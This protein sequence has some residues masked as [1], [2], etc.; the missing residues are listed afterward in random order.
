MMITDAEH[1]FMF[2]LA[3]LLCSLEKCLFDFFAHLVGTLF[4]ILLLSFMSS[5]C[6]WILTPYHN[7]P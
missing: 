1:P 5:L 7:F 3:I 2:L 4:G 6:I